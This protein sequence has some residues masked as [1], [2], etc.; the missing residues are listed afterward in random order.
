VI[1]RGGGLHPPSNRASCASRHTRPRL[2][3]GDVH[4]AGDVVCHVSSTSTS[5]TCRHLPRLPRVQG[6]CDMASGREATSHQRE[7]ALI[8]YPLPLLPFVPPSRWPPS[9]ASSGREGNRRGGSLL[10]ENGTHQTVQAR[11]RPCFQDES[12]YTLS[13]VRPTRISQKGRGP[14][15]IF[16]TVGNTVGT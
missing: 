14:L 11:F 10:G 9:P 1:D 16:P 2:R 6:P 3:A 12:P 4:R 15:L 8:I 7:H 13:T 5:A